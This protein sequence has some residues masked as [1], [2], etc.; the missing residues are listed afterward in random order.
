[1]NENDSK[2]PSVTSFPEESARDRAKKIASIKDILQLLSKCFSQMKI[3]RSDHANVKKFSGQIFTQLAKFLDTHWKLELE[4]KETSFLYDDETVYSDKQLSRSLPFLFYKDGLQGLFFYKG[5]A[6]EEFLD[7]LDLIKHDSE[8]P[9][10]E[11]DIVMALWEKDYA[12]IR[13]YAPD[14]FLESKIGRG[15]ESPQYEVDPKALFSGRIL[16]FPEDESALNTDSILSDSRSAPL[17]AEIS[18]VAENKDDFE[19]EEGA[20][21]LSKEEL[22][23]L[24]TMLENNRSTPLDKELISLLMEMLYLEERPEQFDATLNILDQCHKELLEKGKFSQAL[25]IFSYIEDLS[26]HIA[27]ENVHAQDI[28]SSFLKKLKN[29]DSLSLVM[30][31][32]REGELEDL[33]SFLSYVHLFGTISIPFLAELYEGIK[34]PSY[35]IQIVSILENLAK[36]D[37]ASIVNITGNDH[38]ILTRE[39][40]GIM[41]RTKDRKAIPYLVRFLAFS[42]ESVKFAALKSLGALED[43][44]ADRILVGML[45]NRNEKLRVMALRSLRTDL[46]PS[47]SRSVFSRIR[48]KSF[49]KK[50][51]DEKKAY[52]DFLGRLSSPEAIYTLHEIVQKARRFSG[53]RTIENGVMALESLISASGVEAE[54]ALEDSARSSIRKINQRS[55]QALRN[56][57]SGRKET[58]QE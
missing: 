53:R 19:S 49:H 48:D 44:N 33:N 27:D 46:D 14:D 47:F 3:F 5:L 43:S 6:Q 18:A 39:I 26:S 11:S 7:F 37:L 31:I 2:Y 28:L 34:A 54:A 16:L 45:T 52:F 40:I 35:K 51:P 29:R 13:Y 25:D 30:N 12:N 57:K 20:L 58:A 21:L 15:T 38:P 56:L 24:E 41:G 1:M 4:V 55:R 42:D 10:S 23:V 32:Y 9:P 8:L 50:S 36:E 22:Q 17:S